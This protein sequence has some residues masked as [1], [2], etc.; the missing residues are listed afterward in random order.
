[1]ISH[2]HNLFVLSIERIAVFAFSYLSISMMI[3]SIGVESF[4]VYSQYLSVLQIFGVICL[5]G[6]SS[7]LVKLY[8]NHEFRRV[9]QA[10]FKLRLFMTS[11]LVIIVTV[12]YIFGVNVAPTHLIILCL[13]TEAVRFQA[14]L[15]PYWE[16]IQKPFLSSYIRIVIIGLISILRIWMVYENLGFEYFIYLYLLEI[17]LLSMSHVFLYSMKN[18]SLNIRIT[19]VLP[20]NFDMKVYKSTMYLFISSLFII[21]FQKIDAFIL[22]IFLPITDVGNYLSVL[23]FLEMTNSTMVV[24]LAVIFPLLLKRMINIKVF[25]F[26]GLALS[27]TVAFAIY[28]AFN[29]LVQTLYANLSLNDWTHYSSSQLGIAAASFLTGVRLILSKVIIDADIY[30]YSLISHVVALILYLILLVV[31]VETYRIDG[32]LFSYNMAILASCG[33]VFWGRMKKRDVN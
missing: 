6:S 23:R 13:I 29:F 1:M 10:I 30:V 4:V 5:A 21:S 14:L 16:S 9:F 28:F 17:N 11:I 18:R 8:I 22:P 3:E 15:L 31:V 19:W 12:L 27:L 33:I 7:I 25:L 26:M 24:L 32:V 2:F 20:D